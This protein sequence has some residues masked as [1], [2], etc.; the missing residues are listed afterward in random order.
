MVRLGTPTNVRKQRFVDLQKFAHTNTHT[1]ETKAEE[2]TS[3][4]QHILKQIM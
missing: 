4:M 2:Y 3:Y 1:P